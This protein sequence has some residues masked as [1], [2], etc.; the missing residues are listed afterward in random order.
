M[1]SRWLLVG[2]TTAFCWLA[3]AGSAG[4]AG[5]SAGAGTK[6]TIAVEPKGL[7]GLV[8]S[9]KASRCA[10]GREIVVFR[11]RGEAANPAADKR[12]GSDRASRA[13]GRYR[14]SVRVSSSGR[15]YARAGKVAGCAAGRSATLRF[16]ALGLPGDG[17]RTDYPVCGPYVSEG[18]SEI[19]RF[20]QLHLSLEQNFEC[21]FFATPSGE[22]IGTVTAGLFPWGETG[23]AVRPEVSFTWR[24]A[25]DRRLISFLSFAGPR[26][27]PGIANLEGTVS[28]SGSPA[29]QIDSAWA[30]SELGYPH[31]DRF[32]TP[33]LPGQGPGAVGGPLAINF[34]TKG[35][36][37]GG[38]V[39]I[40][41]YL[42][43]KR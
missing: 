35:S 7:S 39:D 25:G 32:Y 19:C 38:E 9:P 8:S 13:A 33:N 10:A 34:Q 3:L 15:Y 16:A 12:V 43:L 40:Y 18:T 17:E 22:C 20:D 42:Y 6:L 14:W 28:G 4:A 21:R 30:Q 29:L 37:R 5:E 2:V 31:G 26:I 41:G 23:A 11:Q 36:D 1:G 24:P 27:G